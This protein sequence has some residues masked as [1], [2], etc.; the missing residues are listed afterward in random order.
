MPDH[1]ENLDFPRDPVH[2]VDVF[3]HVFFQNFDGHFFSCHVV[4]AKL[5]LAKRAFTYRFLQQVVTNV[6]RAQISA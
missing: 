2:I 3:Y 6:L 4:Y 5:N 1:F